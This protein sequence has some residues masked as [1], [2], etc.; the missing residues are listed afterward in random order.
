MAVDCGYFY[1]S[2]SILVNQYLSHGTLLDLINSYK[3]KV[4][5]V[6][7]LSSKSREKWNN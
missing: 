4:I 7:G 6:K 2:G 3:L 1:D 5:K